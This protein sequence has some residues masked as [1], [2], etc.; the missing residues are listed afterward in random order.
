MNKPV[1]VDIV[2][3]TS[4]NFLDYALSVI[5]S[6]ALP[7]VRDG[8]KPVHRKLIEAMRCL[9]LTEKSSTKKCARIVGDTLG[10]YHR[11]CVASVSNNR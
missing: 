10:K 11:I 6:R 4:K 5:M 2:E 7:D 1:N 8:L 3:K 9:K